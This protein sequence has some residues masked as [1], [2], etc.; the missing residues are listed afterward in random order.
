MRSEKKGVTKEKK[1]PPE[2]GVN[3]VDGGRVG[4]IGCGR[5]EQVLRSWK[6]LKTGGAFTTP[7]P[8]GT[9]PGGGGS[10]G[11]ANAAD[12]PFLRLWDPW[13]FQGAS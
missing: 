8:P 10:D 13:L 7:F 9:R 1:R 6:I 11:F 12:P 3:E 4:G 2:R 5:K